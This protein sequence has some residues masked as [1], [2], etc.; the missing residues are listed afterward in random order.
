MKNIKKN[1][2]FEIIDPINQ[3]FLFSYEKQFIHFIKLF[4][5]KILPNTILVTG[6]KGLGKSTFVFHLVN[7]FLSLNE[8][9]KYV[10]DNFFIN[11]D[12]QSFKLVN[13]NL[14]P[15]FF[16]IKNSSVDKNIKIEQIRNLLSFLN[17]TSPLNNL[18]IVVI[19]DAESLNLNS[20]NALLKALEEPNEN[21][22]FFYN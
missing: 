8:D 19:D 2:E 13:N 6:Q 9:N 16:L 7:Y 3:K 14:H 4:E 5:K 1:I 18:K 22:F 11:E 15:N 20:S 12:N 21:T 10:L 17:K